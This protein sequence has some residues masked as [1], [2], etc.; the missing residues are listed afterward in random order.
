MLSSESSSLIIILSAVAVS[1]SE[2]RVADTFFAEAGSPPPKPEKEYVTGCAKSD[3]EKQ[4]RAVII[5]K[6]F[7]F[8]L[9]L[10]P[11]IQIF[12]IPNI[13]HPKSR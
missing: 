9:I 7:N 4:N 5:A 1:V 13:K 8:I 11:H 10:Y 3:A 6:V 12:A 2:R